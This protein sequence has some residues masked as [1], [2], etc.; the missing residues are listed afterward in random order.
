MEPMLASTCF[1]F[2]SRCIASRISCEGP[3][4]PP[5]LSIRTTTA[6]IARILLELAQLLQG[7]L[8]VGDDAGH[9]HHADP[10]AARAGHDVPAPPALDG[11]PGE[12][13]EGE[14]AEEEASEDEA[15]DPGGAAVHCAA[16]F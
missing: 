3:T 10:L 2:C 5:G 13:H 16:R 4:E 15:E 9:L 14:E 6:R 11:D 7:G 1:F 8:R 12:G